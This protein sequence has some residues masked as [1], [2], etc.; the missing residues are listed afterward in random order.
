[1][2]V[3]FA[4]GCT[5]V[6]YGILVHKEERASYLWC[7]ALISPKLSRVSFFLYSNHLAALPVFCDPPEYIREWNIEDDVVL[8]V[9]LVQLYGLLVAFLPESPLA[10]DLRDVSFDR[11]LL[12][13]ASY[14]V[15]KT[16]YNV[17]SLVFISRLSV[18]ERLKN[19][20]IGP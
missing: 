12:D 3:A 8:V 5:L 4:V 2:A 15:L 18:K 6:G 11:G 9:L 14:L 7:F 20:L 16:R 1:M 13:A 19:V 10:E 17:Y